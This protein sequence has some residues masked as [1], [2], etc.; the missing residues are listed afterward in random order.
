MKPEDIETVI[1]AR[2]KMGRYWR[3]MPVIKETAI[4]D[5]ETWHT[6]MTF[7]KDIIEWLRQQDT[8]QVHL[9]SGNDMYFDINEKLYFLLLMTFKGTEFVN[10]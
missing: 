1:R 9:H 6:V 3:P 5:G 10:K 8:T 7:R 2:K 4:V